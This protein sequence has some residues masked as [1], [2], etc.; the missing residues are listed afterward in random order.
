[1][2]RQ[3]PHVRVLN[4]GI[5]GN[6]VNDLEDRWNSDCIALR[7]DVLTILIGIND[8]WRRYDNDDPTSAE[9]FDAGYRRL[10]TRVRDELGCPVV[11]ME[12]FLTPVRADQ[13]R[14]RE[15]LDPKIEVVRQLARDFETTLL[16]T[17]RVMSDAAERLGAD[18]VAYDGVHPT[19]LGHRL[20]ADTWLASASAASAAQDVN[21]LVPD[22]GGAALS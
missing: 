4:T 13:H 7:P 15:D 10:L 5:S 6:R 22:V 2:R 9:A 19:P 17:D 1:M 20:L 21:P 14:W 12:P 8:T 3:A 16:P 11:L 18:A